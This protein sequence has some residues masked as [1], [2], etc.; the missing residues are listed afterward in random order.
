M[1]VDG[2]ASINLMHYT[3]FRK[4][5]KGPGDLIEIDIMLKYFVGN[6]SKT[7]GGGNECRTDNQE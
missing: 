5:V 4:L 1:L 6:A 2:G 7:R 3:T